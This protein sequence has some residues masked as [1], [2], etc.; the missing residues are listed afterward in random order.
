MKLSKWLDGDPELSG[1]YGRRLRNSGGT[2]FFARWTGDHWLY[3]KWSAQAAAA[4]TE[5]SK[6]P[7]SLFMYRGLAEP[8]AEAA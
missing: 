7:N 3:G 4:V 5:V 1:V 2:G 8:P 6:S